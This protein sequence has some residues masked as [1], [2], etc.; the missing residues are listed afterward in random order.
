MKFDGHKL[1]Y[2]HVYQY[3][4]TEHGRALTTKFSYKVTSGAAER[5]L[6]HYEY[7]ESGDV[8][9][10]F[11]Y[12]VNG[13]FTLNGTSGSRKLRF[14][15]SG[16]LRSFLMEEDSEGMAEKYEFREDGTAIFS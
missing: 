16:K 4:N 5:T 14:Y 9:T 7:N 8:V 6:E 2:F 15:D 11:K 1:E 3:R 13:D 10:N 12:I